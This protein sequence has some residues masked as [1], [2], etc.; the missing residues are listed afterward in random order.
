MTELLRIA[1]WNVNNIKSS[2]AELC[3][4]ITTHDVV[5]LQ[6]VK[7]RDPFATPVGFRVF[8][9]PCAYRASYSGTG[10]VVR[11]DW[12]PILTEDQ[13]MPRTESTLD[14]RA[15][16]SEGRITTVRLQQGPFAGLVI[17]SVYV[18]NSGVVKRD[19]LKRLAYR[20]QRWDPDFGSYVRQ[21]PR[22]VVCGDLNVA[23]R[24]CDVHNPKAL[25]RKAGFTE[26]E[27]TSFRAN[28]G[29]LTDAWTAVHPTKTEYTF[30]GKVHPSIKENRKGWRLDYQL[31][32]GVTPTRAEVFFDY[33][34]S[35]HVPLSVTYFPDG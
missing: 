17:I 7:A 18:P 6:E 1:T 5:C 19:P 12:D 9:S 13:T 16:D 4:L 20:I 25:R 8:W 29:M 31:V 28:L 27:R 26:E 35:D 33:N 15:H 21:F 24:D 22:V 10:M 14:L 32:R 3:Q 11:S 2:A 34:S 23:V 30:Y